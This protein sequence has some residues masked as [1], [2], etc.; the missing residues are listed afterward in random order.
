MDSIQPYMCTVCGYLYDDESA[1]RTVEDRVIPFHELD[2]DWT[3][4]ICGVGP[5]L[6][7]LTESDRIDDSTIDREQK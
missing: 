5:D 4:P 3:C 7:K 6:F 1:E 2:D